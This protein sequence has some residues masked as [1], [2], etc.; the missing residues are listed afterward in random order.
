VDH[1]RDD[2]QSGFSLVELLIAFA[3]LAVI[4]AILVAGI[5]DARRALGAV[6]RRGAQGAVAPVQAVLRRLI[7]EARPGPDDPRP[8]DTNRAFIGE[9]NRLSFV[10]SF[11]PQGQYGGLR[12]YDIG[13]DAVG[14]GSGR[15]VIRHRLAL[16]TTA[17]LPLFDENSA[18]LLEGVGALRVR[19]FGAL[20]QDAPPAWHDIWRHP[21]NL[22]LLVSLDV[23]F[24]Q[25]D[26]RQWI[27]LV[28]G[29]ALGHE[30]RRTEPP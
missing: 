29:P 7:K 18:V 30:A 10:S 19:Y 15:L 22:P 23:R 25:G 14:P 2:R 5:A 1:G 4:A 8:P 3:L 9:P 27:R 6:D 28:I 12:R 17:A 21:V 24:V 26:R 20:D 13:V 16:D 11:V